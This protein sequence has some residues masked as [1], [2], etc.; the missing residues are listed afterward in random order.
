MDIRTHP[1]RMWTYG[2]IDCGQLKSIWIPDRF[3]GRAFFTPD[4]DSN[5]S[6]CNTPAGCCCHQFKNWWLPYNLPKANWQSNPSSSALKRPYP[7]RM[8]PYV[9]IDCGQLKSIWIPDRFCG[10]AFFTPDWDSNP[11]KCNTP[12]G[13]CCHQFKNW[14]LPLPHIRYGC[15]LM[16][17]WLAERNSV[18]D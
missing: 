9:H 16:S 15:R 6:K 5:P 10:R 8:W 13:C 4:W 18:P 7:V 14:W 3:C 12:A 17:L 1:V 11:S 2:H